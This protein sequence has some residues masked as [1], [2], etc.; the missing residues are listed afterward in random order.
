MVEIEL[1]K[2]YLLKRLP[3]NLADCRFEIIRDSFIPAD[4]DHPVIRLR[5]RGGRYE[6]TKKEPIDGI[7][8][9]RQEEHTIKLSQREFEVL[10]TVP[11]QRFAKRRYYCTIDG[12]AAE[13]DVYFEDLEGLA[14]VDFEFKTDEELERF[15]MPDIC[16][17]DVSQERTFAG[18]MLAGKKYVD[19]QSALE[20]HG[21]SPLELAVLT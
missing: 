3:E 18:G 5:Q 19:I 12:F 10:D 21:Y 13:V 4:S 2:T 16:L 11:G 7:D 15:V 9:T 20:Q 14:L 1:E 17:A 8:S 6:I